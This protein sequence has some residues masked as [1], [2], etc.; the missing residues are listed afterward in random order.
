[1]KIILLFLKCTVRSCFSFFSF[2]NCYILAKIIRI[3]AACHLRTSKSHGNSPEP[4]PVHFH[5]L[6]LHKNGGGGA[7][8]APPPFPTHKNQWEAGSYFTILSS[9]CETPRGGRVYQRRKLL[10]CFCV[11][12]EFNRLLNPSIGIVATHSRIWK[13]LDCNQISL[14]SSIRAC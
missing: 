8:L 2:K 4:E 6:R 5:W 13:L 9:N 11:I 1:M 3:V 14:Y 12:L 10:D 7:S